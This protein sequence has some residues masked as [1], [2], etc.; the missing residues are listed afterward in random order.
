MGQSASE[1]HASYF[2]NFHPDSWEEISST[3]NENRGR[4]GDF[5]TLRHKVTKEQIDKYF[6]TFSSAD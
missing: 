1:I 3:P 4:Y 2:P 5:R 6:V